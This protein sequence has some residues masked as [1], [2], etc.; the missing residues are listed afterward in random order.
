MAL[1]R[2]FRF[3]TIPS[4]ICRVTILSNKIINFHPG[5]DVVL[6]DTLTI[7]QVGNII[8]NLGTMLDDLYLYYQILE[9]LT[10]GS[11]LLF[12]PGLLWAWDLIWR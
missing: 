1:K 12:N 3:L 11:G 2:S 8:V 7:L 5:H 6:K 4:D 9:P 10:A